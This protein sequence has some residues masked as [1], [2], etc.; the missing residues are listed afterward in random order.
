MHLK[1]KKEEDV[2]R[3]KSGSLLSYSNIERRKIVKDVRDHHNDENWRNDS[4]I[5][6]K[7]M[8]YEQLFGI[9]ATCF[10]IFLE[11]VP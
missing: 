3:N 5:V 1:C 8:E 7:C 2:I 10:M 9:D 4:S 11:A 6:A